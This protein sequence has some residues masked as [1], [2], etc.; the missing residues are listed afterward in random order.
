MS[1]TIINTKQ[2]PAAIGPYSQAVVATRGFVYTAGQIAIDPSTG[3]I[4]PGGIAEQT[5]QVLKNIKAILEAAGSD[6][7]HI[8][9]TTV[10][11]TDLTEFGAMN[12]AYARFFPDAPPARSTVGV[13]RLPRDARVEIEAIAL[14]AH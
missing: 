12:E 9:K 5:E 10:F 6:L 1:K 2:A 13:S 8:M 7:Q 11:M 4:V 14:V 3:N